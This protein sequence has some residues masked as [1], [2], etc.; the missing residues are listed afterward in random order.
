[1]LTAKENYVGYKPRLLA[2]L[3]VADGVKG[4]FYDTD[5]Q[6]Y[7]G[8]TQATQADDFDVAAAASEDREPWKIS[9][10]TA[11]MLDEGNPQGASLESRLYWEN[12]THSRQIELL[13]S[14]D[15][16]TSSTDQKQSQALSQVSY[17]THNR[18]DRAV[19]GSANQYNQK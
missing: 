10:H 1:M 19:G 2:G 15:N 17:E 7:S 3:D 18:H 14:Q 5:R 13:E 9:R 16:L 6:Y 11:P 4:F 12:K 8:P